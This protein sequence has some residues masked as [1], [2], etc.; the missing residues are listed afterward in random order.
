MAMG[1]EQAGLTGA[2]GCIVRKIAVGR[3]V[4]KLGDALT[5]NS[6]LEAAK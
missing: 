2:K 5:L 4:S 6:T 1:S 3:S